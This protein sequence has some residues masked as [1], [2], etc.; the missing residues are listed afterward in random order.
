[1]ARAIST[2]EAARNLGDFLAG[3]KH[4]G[5]TFILHKNEK[6]VAVLG[7]APGTP[8]ITFRQ[9][10]ELWRKLPDDPEFADDLK[11]VN[12]ADRPPKDPWG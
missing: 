6:P 2:T 10:Y 7:P 4:T 12:K 5:E 1:M 11:A 8:T 3:I 9:F